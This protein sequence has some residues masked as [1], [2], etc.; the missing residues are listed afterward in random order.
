M[1]QVSGSRLEV[2][3]SLEP[4]TSEVQGSEKFI[5]DDRPVILIDTPGFDD[6]TAR[7]GVD[8][9]KMV[10]KFMAESWVKPVR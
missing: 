1:N 3:R 5:L 8:V 2:G 6:G 10:A 7:S 9:L 4:R